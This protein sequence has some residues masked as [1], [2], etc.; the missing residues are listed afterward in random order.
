MPRGLRQFRHGPHQF[1]IQVC[2][3][4]RAIE[5][6]VRLDGQILSNDPFAAFNARQA[7]RRQDRQERRRTRAGFGQQFGRLFAWLSCFLLASALMKACW[8]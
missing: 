3:G 7:Q 8:G 4:L 2:V 6:S 5:G 1:A